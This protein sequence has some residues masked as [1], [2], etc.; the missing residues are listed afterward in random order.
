MRPKLITDD[1]LLDAALTAFANLGYEG[2]SIRAVAREI[3]VSHNTINERFGSKDQL[4]T[5][6]VDHGF[7]ELMSVLAGRDILDATD[8]L[9]ALRDAAERF[10]DY[11]RHKPALVRIIIH[12]APQ[13]GPRFDYM[14]STYIAPAQSIADTAIQRLQQGD[15]VRTGPVAPTF[16]FLVTMGLGSLAGLT[17]LLGRF[18]GADTDPAAVTRLAIDIVFDGFAPRSD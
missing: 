15:R 17:D 7:A 12:E 10:V 2:A 4:W 8:P 14:Y 1:A 5:A 3:G 13:R 11:V 18:S 6:A 16:F 9:A